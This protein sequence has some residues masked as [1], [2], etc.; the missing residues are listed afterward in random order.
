M[1]QTDYLNRKLPVP[2]QKEQYDII[3]Y[4]VMQDE[5]FDNLIA[6]IKNIINSLFEYKNSLIAC[7]VTGQVDVRNIQVEDFDPADLISETDDNP[8]EEEST[9]ESEE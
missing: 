2:P 1:T 5:K 7:V 6:E 4:L 9:E 8:A 3:Q